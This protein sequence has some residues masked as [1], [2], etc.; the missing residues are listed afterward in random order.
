MYVFVRMYMCVYIYVY[1]RM[2]MYVSIHKF[3]TYLKFSKC[4][5]LTRKK[6]IN[7]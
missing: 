1:M 7:K 4:G 5:Q 2:C 3:E 6:S